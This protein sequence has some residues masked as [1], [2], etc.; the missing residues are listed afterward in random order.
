MRV[1]FDHFIEGC[2]ASF[3][4]KGITRLEIDNPAVT[5]KLHAFLNLLRE[6]AKAV[7][8]EDRQLDLLIILNQLKPGP[9]PSFDAFAAALRNKQ[10]GFTSSPNPRYTDIDFNISAPFAESYLS[11]MDGEDRA[12]LVELVGA[13]IH[14]ET[15]ELALA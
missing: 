5:R 2:I 4:S 1:S 15:H 12:L 10:V 14:A 9:I 13:F 6:R 7:E 3:V 11:Q 8:D